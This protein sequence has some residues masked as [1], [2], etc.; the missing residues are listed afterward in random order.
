MFFLGKC[1]IHVSKLVIFHNAS[2]TEKNMR[3]NSFRPCTFKIFSPELKAQPWSVVPRVQR[4]K[5]KGS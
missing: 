5:K 4:G 1:D 3:T 2:W